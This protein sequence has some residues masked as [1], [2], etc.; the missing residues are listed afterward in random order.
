[1]CSISGSI[2]F[3]DCGNAVHRMNAAQLHRGPDDRDVTRC[4]VLGGGEV[5]LGNTRLAIID[6]SP[7]GHQPMNDPETGNWITYNGETYNFKELHR[8]IGSGPWLSNTDTEVV[9]RAYNKWGVDAFRRLRGMFALALWDRAKQQ[10]VLARDTLGIKP[11]YYFVAKDRL[12]FASELRALLASGLTPRRLSAAAVESYLATGSVESPLTIVDGIRQ[13]LPGHYLQVK[14]KSTI[15]VTE[16]KFAERRSVEAPSDRD[17]AVALLRSELEETVR[18]HLVSDVPLGVFL[19]GGMDS[20]ALVAL[21]T[22]MGHQPKTFSVVFDE[23]T[24]TEAPFSRAVAERFDT[25]HSEIRLSEQRLIQL[26]PDAIAA[27]DQP[28]MDGINTFVVSSAVKNAGITVALSGL[29]GD[30]L[31]AGYPSFRRAIKLSSQMSKRVLRAASG[32]GKIAL[33]GSV[34]RHKFWQLANSECWPSDVYRISRQLF[35][36]DSVTRITGRATAVCHKNGHDQSSDVVNEI[37]RLELTGYMTNT[38]LR[39]TDAMSMAHSLEV[40]VPFVDTKLVDYVLSLPGEWKLSRKSSMPKPLLADAL[41]D[42]LP[43]DFLAR[44]K[45]GFTLPFEKWL[46]KDLRTEM[47]SVLRDSRRVSLTGLD[48]KAIEK[49]WDDFL[50]KPRAVGWSRPWSLYVLAQWCEI[51]RVTA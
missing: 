50:V 20:S 14:A 45:M 37:S 1:M 12:L 15:E 10:L 13:L 39:D 29:G 51:N 3:T 49:V 41:A 28:T 4:Q 30:E 11:L 42:L 2:S 35:S 6:T 44:P 34:Q 21:M 48:V 25:V 9:L 19:S 16:V 38:L 33:N 46:Q 24:F 7:A 40:R 18:L 47:S 31:F 26:M 8:E 27:I 32:F 5:V 17:E 36:N 22:R 43:R 23:N